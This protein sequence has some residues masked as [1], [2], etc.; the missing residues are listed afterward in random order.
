MLKN[1]HKLK[2]NN[3]LCLNITTAMMT[4]HLVETTVFFHWI[5]FGYKQVMWAGLR[6]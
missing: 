5:G 4:H 3:Q 6:P 1:S 2:K